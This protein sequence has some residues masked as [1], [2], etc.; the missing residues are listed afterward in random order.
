M[1]ARESVYNILDSLPDDKM[2]DILNVIIKYAENS[3]PFYSDSN[4]SVLRQSI[5]EA[6]E[7]KLTHHDTPLHR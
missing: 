4:M 1:S 6:N 2:P 5:R 7:G 3:D